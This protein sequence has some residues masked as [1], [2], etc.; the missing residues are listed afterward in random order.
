MRIVEIILIILFG[1]SLLWFYA[2]VVGADEIL[3]IVLTLLSLLYFGFGF[4]LFSNVGLRAMFKGGFA[5]VSAATFL[6]AAAT[7]LALSIVTIGILFKLLLMPGANEML[8]IGCTFAG[9]LFVTNVVLYISSRTRASMICVTRLGPFLL[10]GIVLLLTSGLALVKV[11]YRSY[12]L[13]I[14]AYT[15]YSSDPRNDAAIEALDVE[16][17]RIRLN[18]E[19][20]KKYELYKKK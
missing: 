18:E 9:V 13:Y 14:D 15:K 1:L 12:P 6:M 5:G 11:R 2:F 8:T 16:Y 17:K 7:G 10:I 3:M 4:L 19:E 20:F